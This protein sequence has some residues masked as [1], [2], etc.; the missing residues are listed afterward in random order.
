ME[1]KNVYVF[2][3]GERIKD[4]YFAL[5]PNV[6]VYTN[7]SD[8][9][10]L[11]KPFTNV[12]R[13][14]Y[15]LNENSKISDYIN[16]I[17]IVNKYINYINE[18]VYDTNNL[19]EDIQ[20]QLKNQ[21]VRA[22]EHAENKLIKLKDEIVTINKIIMKLVAKGDK[23]YEH[24]IMKAK[25]LKKYKIYIKENIRLYLKGNFENFEKLKIF[26][27]TSYDKIK[28]YIKLYQKYSKKKKYID[29][30]FKHQYGLKKI[31]LNN[32]NNYF[33]PCIFSGNLNNRIR[34][35]IKNVASKNLLD[36][37]ICP[38]V[39]ITKD[40]NNNFRDF[41]AEFPINIEIRSNNKVIVNKKDIQE[42]INKYIQKTLNKKN[43][44]LSYLLN[45]NMFTLKELRNNQIL[46]TTIMNFTK[47]YKTICDI[48]INNKEKEK[49]TF[50]EEL[51]NIINNIEQINKFINNYESKHPNNIPIESNYNRIEKKCGVYIEEI[52]EKLESNV[53]TS[54]EKEIF[55][56]ERAEYILKKTYIFNK[57]Y[58]KEKINEKELKE[59][60]IERIEESIN[61]INEKYRII[62]EK[63][64]NFYVKKNKNELFYPLDDWGDCNISTPFGSI[65]NEYIQEY[66]NNYN[67]ESEH[68]LFRYYDIRKSRYLNLKECY[69]KHKEDYGYYNDELSFNL[70]DLL[71]YLYGYYELNENKDL[72]LDV[73][74]SALCLSEFIK[75]NKIYKTSQL[76]VNDY[77]T[78][79]YKIDGRMMTLRDY[80]NNVSNNEN[81]IQEKVR[82]RRIKKSCSLYRV[83]EGCPSHC[84]LPRDLK[85]ATCVVKGRK[86]DFIR[87][88]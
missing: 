1:Y 33:N 47:K 58:L 40:H 73:D 65:L 29:Y 43:D 39:L 41:I 3:H 54:E 55:I 52:N 44:D 2:G 37:N 56:E 71:I 30:A 35:Y 57:K 6:R 20:T 72:K 13:M 77:C 64:Y 61:K 17:K 38:N 50:E 67:V 23:K 4:S 12:L 16:T 85:R 42:L 46:I 8:T 14:K 22:R 45:N 87:K 34:K 88:K 68:V 76:N 82:G 49:N 51:Q 10:G 74:I 81:V 28:K 63:N 79:L 27:K 21:S 32:Y 31:R 53:Y 70:R 62:K 84:D 83:A 5:E 11:F 24:I 60:E 48:D 19:L 18:Y 80:D 86:K 59:K 9:A 15:L 36:L 26:D 66:L 75:P 7:C 25:K 78:K 69:K